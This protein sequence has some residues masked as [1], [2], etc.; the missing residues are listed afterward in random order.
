MKNKK[1]ED[2]KLN[3]AERNAKRHLESIAEWYKETHADG[4]STEGAEEVDERMRE[5]ALEVCTRSGWRSPGSEP[6]A[7]SEFY[8]LL[9]TGG[10]ALR[11]WGE[12]NEYHEPDSDSLQLQWQD[13]GTPWTEY[14][15][16]RA[17]REALTAFAN[18]FYFGG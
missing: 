3:H 8:I 7:D 10:P 11:L 16:A 5:S 4:I 17:E 1:E 15:P 2:T 18:L 9:T 6:E 14:G 13:W 12:L